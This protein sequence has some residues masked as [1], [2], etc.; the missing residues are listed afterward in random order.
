MLHWAFS[1]LAGAV[2]AVGAFQLLTGSQHLIFAIASD[3]MGSPWSP[4]GLA[5]IPP[6]SK[7]YGLSD[8]EIVEYM[9]MEGRWEFNA[10]FFISLKIQALAFLTYIVG[11]T[12][13]YVLSGE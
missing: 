4:L 5:N 2:A 10:A 1:I 11:R 9:I 7:T 3:M 8:K 6:E 12:S 13:R